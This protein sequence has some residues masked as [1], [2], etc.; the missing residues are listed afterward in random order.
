MFQF[1]VV[2]STKEGQ[3]AALKSSSAVRAKELRLSFDLWLQVLWE[4]TILFLNF[5]LLEIRQN[6]TKEV[7]PKTQ[8]KLGMVAHTCR[9]TIS[10]M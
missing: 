6:N 3:Q 7:R 8:R 9:P 10:E 4:M 5:P 1:G 2:V